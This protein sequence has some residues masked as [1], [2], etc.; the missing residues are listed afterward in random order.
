[1]C[2]HG[3]TIFTLQWTS[4]QWIAQHCP[5][6]L[7]KCLTCC[8][9]HH[10]LSKQN[11]V[12]NYLLWG[13]GVVQHHSDTAPTVTQRRW[14]QLKKAIRITSI[15]WQCWWLVSVGLMPLLMPDFVP[16]SSLRRADGKLEWAK[17]TPLW[18]PA[19]ISHFCAGFIFGHRGRQEMRSLCLRLKHTVW[20][21]R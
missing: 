20:P 1:M 4:R 2:S 7:I 11:H 19:L 13:V 14:H 10:T 15:P 18:S 9:T 5:A 8:K 16:N 21:Q 12:C 17:E 3:M 6:W